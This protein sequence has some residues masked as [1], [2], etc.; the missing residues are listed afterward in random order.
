M[1]KKNKKIVSKKKQRIKKKSNKKIVKK[2]VKKNINRKIIKKIDKKN[3]KAN[4]VV[5]NFP[6]LIEKFK[7]DSFVIPSSS[8]VDGEI[9]Y[10]TVIIQGQF[11]GTIRALEVFILIGAKITGEIFC[12]KIIN[13]GIC[14]A[15]IYSKNLCVI[16]SRAVI[17]GDINYDGDLSIEVGG[18]VFGGLIPK[19]K[20]LAL[21][22]YSNQNSEYQT[23]I[24][25]QNLFN[26][27]VIQDTSKDRNFKPKDKSLDNII[28][29]IFK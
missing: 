15:N 5:F 26:D 13:Y 2:L 14:H 12:N 24:P 20:P 9:N 4:S 27:N 21:P 11:N 17:K 18:K 19:R 25:S 22:N 7:N 6:Q 3:Q 10:H 28:S 16:K 29:K 8:K 1:I 23:K